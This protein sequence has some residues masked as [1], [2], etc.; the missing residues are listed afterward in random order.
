MSHQSDSAVQLDAEPLILAALSA[1]LG[2][3]LTPQRFTL[4]EGATADVDGASADGNVLVEVFAHQGALKGGQRGKIA[5]DA[6]KLITLGQARP[7]ARLILALADPAAAKPLTAKSW[8][9]EALAT[10]KIEVI[11]VELDAAVRQGIRDAQV[12][13][14]MVNAGPAADP[15]AS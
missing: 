12:R 1:Q 14:V 6:L 13:Q 9:A 3:P 4:P 7:G 8:L 5:R 10:F 15:A 2:T 11:V